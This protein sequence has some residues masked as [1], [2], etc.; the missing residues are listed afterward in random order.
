M[1]P[2][3][4]VVVNY[5]TPV[6]AMQCLESLEAEVR[7]NPGARVTVVD[8]ASADGSAEL[9][10]QSIASRGWSDWARFIASP[11]NGGFAAGN[12]LAI[13]AALE[14]GEPLER[15]WLV[16]P[17]AR[18]RPGALSTLLAFMEAH[19]WAGIAGGGLD[20]AD[21]KPWPYAFRFPSVWSEFDSGLGLGVVS[22]LLSSHT[23]ARRMGQ[24]P[25]RVDWISG[26]NFMVRREVI[27][28]VGLM[29]A[30]Y[31]LYY[32]ETDYCLQA[33]RAGWEC[34]YVPGARVLHLAGQS[35]GIRTGDPSR[36]RRPSYWFRSRTRY[37]I[38][39]HG[40]AY[41]AATDLL[42]ILGFVIWRM[43]RIVQRKPKAHPAHFLRDFVQHSVLV[44]PLAP[45]PGDHR[46]T[47]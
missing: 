39:S 21:G 27:E 25:E 35:T 3:L 42:W 31:F 1:T 28:R 41:T 37:F 46:R 20:D 7:A 4:I 8:N 44:S 2:V 34:W 6:L 12:N 14:A 23:V 40:K 5:R 33:R 38:R 47:S 16:N 15:V 29:D 43:R 11:V 36:A 22:R 30:G 18:V 19:P 24:E 17:D 10:P 26:A 45:C 13:R 9:I 32:E